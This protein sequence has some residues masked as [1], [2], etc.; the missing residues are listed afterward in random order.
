MKKSVERRLDI[1]WQAD[2]T[3]RYVPRAYS[4]LSPGWGVW[5]RKKGEFIETPQ[6]TSI[7]FEE[8]REPFVN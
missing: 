1:V 4:P 5:D 7:T 8:L 3:R 2:K 6:L